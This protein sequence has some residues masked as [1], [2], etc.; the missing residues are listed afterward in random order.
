M[1]SRFHNKYHR[2][3]HHSRTEGDPRYPDAGHDPI[4]SPDFPFLGPFHLLGTLSAAS[5]RPFNNGD[6]TPAAAFEGDPF[7]IIVTAPTSGIAIQSQGNV[8]INGE[9]TATGPATVQE[10]R[11]T[12]NVISTYST[13]VT[14]TGDFLLIKVGSALKA[15]RLWNY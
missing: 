14:A 7:G 4:A 6:P 1:S 10:I 12:G 15:I 5:L 13:P 9:L 3:N 11:F 2:H 8:T